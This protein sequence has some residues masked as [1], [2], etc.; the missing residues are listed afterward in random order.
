M[1][2][3]YDGFVTITSDQYCEFR[4]KL[5]TIPQSKRDTLFKA[6]I[7]DQWGCRST[8]LYNSK[9]DQFFEKASKRPV[10]DRTWIRENAKSVEYCTE[11]GKASDEDII[12]IMNKAQAE[13]RSSKVRVKHMKVQ[14][15]RNT[16]GGIMQ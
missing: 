13:N 3:F 1:R 16:T 8:V 11:L 4:E 6:A 9:K 10:M 5:E 12:D 7:Y 15:P 14:I 2:A